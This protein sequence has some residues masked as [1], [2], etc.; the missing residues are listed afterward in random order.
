MR[1]IALTT[2]TTVETLQPLS[3]S[4]FDHS[5]PVPVVDAAVVDREQRLLLIRRAD[6]GLWA[7]PGGKIEVGETAAEAAEREVWEECGVSAKATDLIGIYD[8]HKHGSPIVVQ[9]FQFVFLCQPIPSLPLTEPHW[10]Q[11]LEI[12]EHGWFSAEN[13]PPNL[14]PNHVSRIPHV[15]EYLESQRPFFDPTHTSDP[16]EQPHVDGSK[17]RPK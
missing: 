1:L 8:S 2:G 11:A 4:L 7:M 5:G 9:L 14:D 17:T 15:F 6:N 13:I 3:E 12:L 16:S 10:S